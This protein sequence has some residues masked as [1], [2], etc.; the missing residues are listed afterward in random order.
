[1]VSGQTH[2]PDSWTT[3]WTLKMVKAYSGTKRLGETT[4]RA[5]DL[6]STVRRVPQR[7][8]NNHKIVRFT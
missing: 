5:F 2:R 1:M 3:L 8:L 6:S 7:L 4:M